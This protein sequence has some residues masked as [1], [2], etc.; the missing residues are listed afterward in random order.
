MVSRNTS[1]NRRFYCDS[2]TDL[3]G[4]V[5]VF[6]E[7]LGLCMQ[8]DLGQLIRSVRHLEG[9]SDPMCKGAPGSKQREV[10]SM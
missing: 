9:D 6:E 5:D 4:V 1:T 8:I 2:M 10:I 3:A 7:P